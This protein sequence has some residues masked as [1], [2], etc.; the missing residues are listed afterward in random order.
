MRPWE[1]NH[2]YLPFRAVRQGLTRMFVAADC[3]NAT[4]INH[5]AACWQGLL[6]QQLKLW[7]QAAQIRQ[8]RESLQ[9]FATL[10][11]A[12][13]FAAARACHDGDLSMIEMGR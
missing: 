13:L 6:D 1:T 11:K 2:I 12:G 8:T 10:S 4:L 5:F 9:I 7:L 3:H